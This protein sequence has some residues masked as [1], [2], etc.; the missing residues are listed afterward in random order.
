MALVV[1]GVKLPVR[2][3]PILDI[4]INICEALLVLLFLPI[5][6][7]QILEKRHSEEDKISL[8]CHYDKA[9]ITYHWR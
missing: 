7:L 3:R 6:I 9:R 8:C 1:P 5:T 4:I 2:T